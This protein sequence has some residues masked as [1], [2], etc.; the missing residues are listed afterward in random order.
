MEV[1]DAKRINLGVW[2]FGV[3]PAAPESRDAIKPEAKRRPSLDRRG[4]GD[5]AR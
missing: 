5:G 2:D 3:H 1:L 4:E